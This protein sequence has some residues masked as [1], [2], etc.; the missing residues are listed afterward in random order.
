[1]PRVDASRRV[2]QSASGLRVPTVSSELERAR[3]T[4][5]ESTVEAAFSYLLSHR[6]RWV[7]GWE[8]A[9]RVYRGACSRQAV[10][11]II[12]R[13]RRRLG[14][15]IESGPFG[16]R[17]GRAVAVQLPCPQCG[18][19][20]VRYEEEWVCYGCPGTSVVDMEVGRTVYEPGSRQGKS[21]TKEEIEF[22]RSNP[23]LSFGDMARELLR[24]ESSVR[25]VWASLGLGRKP[26]ARSGGG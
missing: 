16:Y 6:G 25:A 11:V 9:D 17:V 3:V 7:P 14:V 1:M 12:Y 20:R 22:V 10:S 23:G 2:N 18:A 5:H 19:Q 21:W 13:A 8:L 26:Y 24:T 4:R 15:P